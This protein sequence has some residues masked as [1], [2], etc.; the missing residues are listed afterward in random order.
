[1]DS[2]DNTYSCY[3]IGLTGGIASGKSAVSQMF[4][5]LGCDII[6]ADIIAREVV[7]VG[8]TG[9]NG[10][11]AAFGE[12]ILTEGKQL[13]RLSLRK[14][15]FNNSKKLTL[16]NSILHPLIQQKII[17]KAKLVN[18]NYCIIVIPLLC[19]ADSYQWLDRILV[20]DVLPEVQLQRLMQRDSISRELADKM[21]QSQCS[22]RQRLALADDVIN[23]EQSL[24]D[25]KKHVETLNCLYKQFKSK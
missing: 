24:L 1:M 9:L 6:D 4:A 11:V 14:I 12:T 20:V 15:V 8:S 25:L 13:D 19:E 2:H 17:N 21:M 10:L 3:T 16:L 22:R 23:N 5:D 18:N 7:E